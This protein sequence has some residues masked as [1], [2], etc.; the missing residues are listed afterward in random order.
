MDSS[1]KIYHEDIINNNLQ[2]NEN[3]NEFIEGTMKI[4]SLLNKVNSVNDEKK[5]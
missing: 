2:N 5:I 4:E 3:E 1:K